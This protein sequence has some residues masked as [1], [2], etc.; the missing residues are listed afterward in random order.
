[1]A[2]AKAVWAVTLAAEKRR[3]LLRVMK[4]R[5]RGMVV[6]CDRWP[7]MQFTGELDGPRLQHWTT[8]APWQRRLA[9][10]ELRPYELARRFP[11]D[12]VIRL[13]VDLD[14]AAQRRSEDSR[15]YLARRIEL[16]QALTFDDSL[17]GT[18]TVDATEPPDKVLAATLRTIWSRL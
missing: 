11:P 13:D 18:V 17:F 15:D 12:L 4:A 9:R 1:M 2:T 3:K 10:Y 6:I 8:G 16:V 7:Q 5:T 14:T